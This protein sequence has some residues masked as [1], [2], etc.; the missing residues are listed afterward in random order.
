MNKISSSLSPLKRN[1]VAVVAAATASAVLSQA[2]P[3]PDPVFPNI[4]GVQLKAGADWS[5]ERLTEAQSLGFRIV[6]KGMYWSSVEKTRGVYDFS[7]Y[8]DE[9]AYATKLGLRVSITLFGGNSLYEKKDGV[10]GIITEEGRQ[11]FAGFAAAAAARYKGTNI[12]FEIWNEPNVRTFWGNHGT[13]NTKQFANE[14]SALVN[15]VTP[16][17]LKENPKCFVVAGSVSNYW[18]PSYQW[19]EFCFQNGVLKSGISAWSVHPYGVKNPEQHEVG[20]T[21]TRE[22][23]KKYGAPDMPIL[24]TERGYAVAKT[25]TGEGWSGG[26]AAKTLNYQAEHFIRQLL[27]DHLCGVRFSVWYEWG[28]NEGFGMW[29]PD[30]SARPVV[31]SL[32][33]LISELEGYGFSERIQG[34]SKQ[35]YLA[36]FKNAKGEKKIAAW[37]SPPAGGSPDETWEHEVEIE[38]GG[39]HKPITIKLSGHPKYVSIPANSKP[40]KAVTTTPVPVAAPVKVE[41][42]QGAVDLKLFD[43]G[44]IWNFTKNTGE[45]SF[46]LG[47]DA[48]GTPIG[49]LNYDFS[50]SKSKSTPYVIA[51]TS[52]EVIKP[53]SALTFFARSQNAQQLT[54]RVVDSTGQTLQFKTR[55]KGTGEWEAIRFPLDRKLENWDGAK[56]GFAHFPLK[57]L[58]FSV[59]KPADVENGK[60][61]YAGFSA[62]GSGI[63]QT[64]ASAAEKPVAQSRATDTMSVKLFDV[65]TGELSYTGVVEGG[66]APVVSTPAS[67]SVPTMQAAPKLAPADVPAVALPEGGLALNLFDGSTDWNFIK[68][69][70]EGS[71]SFKKD[72]EGRGIGIISYDFTKSEARSTPYVLASASVSIPGGKGIS[73]RVRT[74]VPQQLTFRVTDSTGQTLQHKTKVKG[75]GDWETVRF[76]LDRKL[77]HWDGANDGFVHFPLK[78]MVLSVPQ[79]PSVSSGTVEYAEAIAE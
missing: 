26:E 27:V 10:K 5:K 61:E 24:N 39:G 71:F 77:E 43:A 11:G 40:V 16:A 36:I 54:F 23:L 6:R 38:L 60:V 35:D 20:H 31:A 8:D 41:T 15:T 19:T 2:Q 12:L 73:M 33:E 28:G 53:C 52:L 72:A 66:S 21:R 51:S 48:D 69:T 55:I 9:I 13:H 25:A 47:K 37:T 78:S 29:N 74:S 45:G 76:P 14:Y 50:K 7:E 59:P 46:E 4:I 56:D 62:T 64:Q 79:P 44:K 68:N 67:P 17:M 32:K 42:P 70:G 1:T 30:G 75:S 65:K 58:V 34:D 57:T 3:L 63:A 18:E 49:I 22:L